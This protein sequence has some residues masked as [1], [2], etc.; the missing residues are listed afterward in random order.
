MSNPADREILSIE[1]AA[2]LLGVSIKTFNKVLH[3]SDLPARKIGREWKFS[4]QALIEWVGSGRSS[5]FYRQQEPSR[6]SM[7]TSSG[8]R[9]GGRSRFEEEELEEGL[10]DLVMFPRGRPSEAGPATTTATGSGYLEVRIDADFDEFS[11][12]DGQRVL[13]VLAAHAG[14]RIDLVSVSRGS[15]I[16][17][18]ALDAATAETL[19]WAIRRGDLD[20]LGVHSARAVGGKL[21]EVI[22]GAKERE[23]AFDIL[24]AYNRQDVRDAE[25]LVDELRCA[26][27][28]AWIDCRDMRAGRSWHKEV[29]SAL[30]RIPNAGVLL[31]RHG[32]GTSQ[33][34]EVTYLIDEC[35]RDSK[36]VIPILLEEAGEEPE[37]PDLLR[38]NG[39]I[40]LRRGR[41]EFDRLVWSIIPHGVKSVERPAA[42]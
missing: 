1:Q 23:G 11:S 6:R 36:P 13:K 7:S 4:R 21:A 12:A 40:D 34:L 17:K 29:A 26:S 24:L 9:K 18:L 20:S 32:V 14:G 22:V 2:R 16:L 19:Y 10:G 41:K 39:T 33:S 38:Q 30:K 35:S 28:L 31:G 8:T 15:V 27:V 25:R 42:E 3:S 37:V 5:G